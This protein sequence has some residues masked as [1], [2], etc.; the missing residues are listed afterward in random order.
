MPKQE[1]QEI[2]G[3][4][5]G[6]L[7]EYEHRRRGGGGDDADGDEDDEFGD[8][9]EGREEDPDAAEERAHLQVQAAR[10]HLEQ[11][12]VIP[13]QPCWMT[14]IARSSPCM[15]ARACPHAA[16]SHAGDVFAWLSHRPES[17]GVPG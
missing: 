1:A 3:D 15:Q 13:C 10:R 16:W 5:G 6:L 4:V 2:F 9:L 17:L 11:H 7:E 14:A 8:G 12:C